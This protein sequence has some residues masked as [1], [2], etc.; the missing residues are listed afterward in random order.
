MQEAEDEDISILAETNWRNQRKRFGIRQGDRRAHMHVIGKTGTGKSTLLGT[1]LRQDLEQGRGVALFDPHGDLVERALEWVPASRRNDLVYLDVPNV[2]QSFSFNPLE[3]VPP[4]KRP[5]AAS[6]LL[7][8]FKK[9]WA[10][11]W[12]PRLEYILHNALI[13]L[14]D[15][16]EATLADV[17]RIL[18]DA[19]Y[20]RNAALRCWNPQ[21]RDF[22]LKEFEN[23]PKTFRLEAITPIQNKVGAFLTDPVLRSILVQPKSSLICGRL[24]MRENSAGKFG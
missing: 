8:V 15:Q 21:V 22:W 10:D 5:L 7:D 20:R 16:P 24:W 2:T 19:L 18:D 14:L 4:L 9:N 6:G 17:L 12:G 11:S 3:T 23:Y 13:T 1:L